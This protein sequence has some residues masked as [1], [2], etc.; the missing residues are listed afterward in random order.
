MTRA[1]LRGACTFALG[2]GCLPVQW[3]ESMVGVSARRTPLV[4]IT[5]HPP[6]KV[7]FPFSKRLWVMSQSCVMSLGREGCLGPQSCT[8]SSSSVLAPPEG[9]PPAVVLAG[10]SQAVFP[11]LLPAASCQGGFPVPSLPALGSHLPVLQ[12][13][14]GA[15]VRESLLSASVGLSTRDP[16][17]VLLQEVPGLGRGG[18]SPHLGSEVKHVRIRFTY[19]F[20]QH[21]T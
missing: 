16:R 7:A 5:H 14:A 21:D 17:R 10:P 20:V 2:G 12:P 8:K 19:E 13:Q 11:R 6:G 4:Q 18:A 3:P 1:T 9:Q 15:H